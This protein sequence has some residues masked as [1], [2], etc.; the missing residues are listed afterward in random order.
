MDKTIETVLQ[1]I[2]DNPEQ[3]RHTFLGLNDCCMINGSLM[4]S[5]I[6]AHGDCIDLGINGGESCDVT[7]GPCACGAWH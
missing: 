1:D 6:D 4:L 2:I 7:E 5:L 3:H